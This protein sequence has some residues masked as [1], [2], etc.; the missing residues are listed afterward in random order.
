M[1]E[2]LHSH[3]CKIA[4]HTSLKPSERKNLSEEAQK[5]KLKRQMRDKLSSAQSLTA[6][7]ILDKI[8]VF[9]KVREYDELVEVLESLPTS[10]KQNLGP[11]SS[12]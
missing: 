10:R 2:A 3:L 8:H 12:L 1:A 7:A 6:N 9:D 11:N 5:E 4:R